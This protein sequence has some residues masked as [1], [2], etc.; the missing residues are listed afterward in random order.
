MSEPTTTQGQGEYV[1]GI[2]AVLI[3]FIPE[4]EMRIPG[5]GDWGFDAEYLQIHAAGDTL[6][7]QFL[8]ALHEL[9]EAWLCHREGVDE[10]AVDEHD[11]RFEAER[12]AGLHGPDEEPGD[13]PFA[14]YRTQH[15]RA[16]IVEHL[17]ANFLSLVDY[18]VIR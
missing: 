14:P 6:D 12:Q 8:V 9:V 5:L 4:S 11:I 15:R 17:V 2:R 3:R 1:S 10:R 18:G 7:E 16:A 13:S